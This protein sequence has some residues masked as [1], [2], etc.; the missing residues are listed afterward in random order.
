[1]GLVDLS[2]VQSL[3]RCP[4]CREALAVES[5]RYR[6]SSIRCAFSSEAFPAVDR[7]PAFVDFGHSILEPDV[8]EASLDGPAAG[9]RRWGSDRLPGWLRD[10]FVKPPNQVATRNVALLLSL[11]AGSSPLVL[12]IGGGTVGNGVEEIYRSDRARMLAFDIYASPFT[13]FIADAH[14][15]PLAQDSVDAVLIQAVLEHVLDP[16]EV[17]SEV[18]R[19]LKPGGLVYAE[20]PFLQ[21][22]HAG[23]YD[24]VRFTSSGHRYLFRSFEEIDAGPVAG[25]GTQLMWSVD[26]LVRGLVRSELAGKLARAVLFWLR[27]L[28]RLIP[29][30]FAMDNA[31]AYY[32]LGRASQRQLSPQ[33]IL[34]YYRGAQQTAMRPRQS[35]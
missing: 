10:A 1:M 13:Q 3:L 19:V 21:Q 14:R 2:D 18:H 31:S 20:T 23:P 34:L 5:G 6:C 26:H 9:G 30:A 15:I 27:Y 32:F 24:F 11:L 25:A 7:W 33:E 35:A 4:R 29:R 8:L 16:D 17:I 12:V 22:V 28:D